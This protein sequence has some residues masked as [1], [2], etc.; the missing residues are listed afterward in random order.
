MNGSQRAKFRFAGSEPEAA[1]KLVQIRGVLSVAGDDVTGI[2]GPS[3]AGICHFVYD[4]R[5]N[6]IYL[7]D[8]NAGQTFPTSLISIVGVGGTDIGG[9][10]TANPNCKIRAAS[11]SSWKTITQASH[12]TVADVTLDIEFP[13][14][15]RVKYHI[16]SYSQSEFGG[17]LPLRVEGNPG[18]TYRGYWWNY[19]Q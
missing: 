17:S 11:S 15:P 18:W 9:V 5:S 13:V 1:S 16:Y 12:Q 4:P 6:V 19:A 10:G 7:D 2:G 14:S 3:G 8:A